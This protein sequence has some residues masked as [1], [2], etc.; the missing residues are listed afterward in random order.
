MRVDLIAR[1]FAEGFRELF[2]MILKLVS[3]YGAKE[4][5][6]KLRGEWVSVAPRDWRNGFE[7]S[8]NVGLGTGNKDQQV[9]FLMALRQQQD[10]GLQQG[11]ATPENVYQAQAELV[12][13]LGFKSAEKFFTDPAKS[14]PK[15]QQPGPMD[16]ERMKAQM[17]QQ[18]AQMQAQLKSQG[19]TQAKQAELALERERMQMQAQ[20]DTH[21]QQVEAQQKA[22]EAQSAERLEQIKVQS[23]MQLEQFKAQMQQETA[24]AVAKIN[25]EAVVV[26]AQLQ[27]SATPAIATPSMDA[28]ADEVV[29]DDA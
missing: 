1:N 23:Q 26:R 4:D 16:I 7:V 2:R 19:D 22:L 27:A 5:V 28:A 6:V 17:T 20:V 13:A 8:V 10:I 15:Q 3:Q 9:Q 12:K 21:R 24:I 25:A 18:T 14:P 11:T 29:N